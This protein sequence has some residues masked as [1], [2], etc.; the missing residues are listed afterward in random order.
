[1]VARSSALVAAL[2]LAG[3]LAT[4]A[5]ARAADTGTAVLG[6]EAIDS[7]DN[8]LAN[9]ITEAIKQRVATGKGAPLIPGKDLVEIKLVFSCSDEAP[10]CLAQAG[11]SLGAAKVIYG[12]IKRSGGDLVLTLKEL[13]ATRGVIDGSTVENISKKKSD[14]SA[15][16]ALSLQW[17]SR[18]GGKA[19]GAGAA[20]T[21]AVGTLTVR[22]NV[23]GAVVLLDGAEVGTVT[24]KS[25]QIDDVA[26]GKHEIRVEKPGFGVTT[27][28]FTIGAGQALPLTLTLGSEVDYSGGSAQANGAGSSEPDVTATRRAAQHDEGPAEESLRSWVRTGFW[29]GLGLTAVSFGVAAKY[30]LEVRSVNHD[31]DLYRDKVTSAT[32]PMVDSK[33]AEGNRAETRQWIFVGVGS[34]CAVAG[35]FLLYKGYLDKEAGAGPRTADNH[36]LRVFPTADTSSRGIAAEFDF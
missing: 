23:A 16:R 18:L 36:G 9:D 24:R 34:A 26:P 1:M 20:T 6:I 33:L 2:A 29:I 7:Q 22:C 5:A 35:G 28:Q 11:K 12:N 21:M 10:D 13:D 25:L 3:G 27:Q 30:G 15:L 32:Q 4:S 14:P 8:A 19:G 31:L 17:L